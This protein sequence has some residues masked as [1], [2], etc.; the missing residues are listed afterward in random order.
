MTIDPGNLVF[1]GFNS[2]VVALD[3]DSGKIAW[4]WSAP[5]GSGYVSLLLIDDRHLIASVNGYTYCL[6]PCSGGQV[7][8]NGLSGMGMGVTSIVAVDRKNP[9]DSLVA[10][11]QATAANA[12]AAGT[13]GAAGS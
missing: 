9:H 7:W 4:D 11:A 2:H 10:S 13:A 6:D 12:S 1:V 3:R 5:H 8:Y